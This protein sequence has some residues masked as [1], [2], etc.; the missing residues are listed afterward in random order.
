MLIGL[1]AEGKTDVV[2][3]KRIIATVLGIDSSDIRA[4]RPDDFKDETD[5]F[6]NSTSQ[7]SNWT[8]VKE[9]CIRRETIERF[10]ALSDENFGF[11]IHLDTDRANEIGY[12]N[13]KPNKHNNLN[14]VVEIRQAIKARIDMWLGPHTFNLAYA[15]A[16]EESE[17]WLLPLHINLGNKSTD[18]DNNPKSSLQATP[19]YRRLKGNELVPK[20]EKLA[21][22]LRKARELSICAANNQSLQL[23][24]EELRQWH[25]P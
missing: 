6:S 10:F 16:V 17:A 25:Q 22:P 12:N 11:V 5:K 21:T 24:I 23:F 18:F 1:I 8:I 3:I 14:Y 2:I 7:F 19:A 15:V 4:F 9:E 20:Y 13:Y